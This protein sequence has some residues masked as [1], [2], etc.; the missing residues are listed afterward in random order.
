M[1]LCLAALVAL[2]LAAGPITGWLGQTAA[3][4][5][6]PEAYIAANRLGVAE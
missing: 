5:D 3:A 2:T 4:L 6:A 1:L